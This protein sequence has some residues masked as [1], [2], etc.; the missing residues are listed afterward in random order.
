MTVS[1]PGQKNPSIFFMP[2]FGSSVCSLELVKYLFICD[3]FPAGVFA[4]R[5][6]PDQDDYDVVSQPGN[7]T[8]SSVKTTHGS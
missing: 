8:G 3:L 2:M 5:T 1:V 4:T 7:R 6:T